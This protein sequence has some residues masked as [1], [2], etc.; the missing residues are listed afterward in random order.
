[1]QSYLEYLITSIIDY[2][3]IGLLSYFKK[4][5]NDYMNRSDIFT[6]CSS[7][8][9]VSLGMQWGAVLGFFYPTF[10]R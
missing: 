1:M 3:K 10:F 4:N 7:R 2:K 8:N 9:T 6:T 5:T